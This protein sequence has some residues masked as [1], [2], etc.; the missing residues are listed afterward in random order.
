[1]NHDYSNIQKAFLIFWCSAWALIFSIESAPLLTVRII[2]CVAS[3]IFMWKIFKINSNSVLS[4]FLLAYGI[5]NVLYA[6]AFFII[7]L[8]FAPLLSD[9]SAYYS[10][11]NFDEPIYLLFYTLVAAFQLL[12]AYLFFKIRRFKLG[13]PYLRERNAKIATLII[14]GI[15]LAFG[16][17]IT[18]QRGNAETFHM[19]FSVIVGIAVIALGIYIWIRMNFKLFQRKKTWERNEE[20]YI[21]EKNELINQIEYYKEI[22]DAAMKANHKMIYRQIVAERSII[23]ILKNAQ[24]YEL[25]AELSNELMVEL[26]KI[27]ALSIEYQEQIDVK[28]NKKL[29]STNIKSIDGMFAFFAERFAENDIDFNLK[30]NGSILYMVEEIVEQS[31]LETMIGDHLKDALDAVNA[32]T[33]EIRSVLAM[34]G[35]TDCC[36][37]F[38]V[39][40]SGISF[41]VHT[42]T[43]LGLDYVTTHAVDGGSGI[44]FMTTFETIRDCGAS[45]IIKEN[46]PGSAFSKVVTIRFD[47]EDKYIIKTYRP[48][49]FPPNDRYIIIRNL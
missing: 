25:P 41:E 45:L 23:E 24:S 35:E 18:A 2:Y 39:Q 42:L 11:V 37:E 32:G 38:S 9:A 30:V 6:I 21:Q 3:I 44:G 48:E 40:D 10:I 7:G 31:K 16:S 4:A 36:Y 20:I 15:I 22:H 33:G 29:P 17:L 27:Q 1:M 13:I 49:D 46:A 34:I 26:Q 19:I 8:I 28:V 12:I 14:S 43:R 47:G 5:S